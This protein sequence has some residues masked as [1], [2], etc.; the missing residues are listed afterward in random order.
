MMTVPSSE[1][2]TRIPLYVKECE[3]SHSNSTRT[4]QGCVDHRRLIEPMP[5][6]LWDACCRPEEG[7]INERNI[8]TLAA[9]DR[10]N[11]SAPPPP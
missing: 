5:V 10:L 1:L 8:C 4:G 7:G 6:P 3:N 9:G 11:A 2:S